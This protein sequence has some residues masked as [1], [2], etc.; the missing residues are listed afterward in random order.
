M[1]EDQK[2]AALG[3]AALLGAALIWGSGFV[4]MKDTLN[5]VS[6]FRLLGIRFSIGLALMSLLFFRRYR[7]LNRRCLAHGIIL[8][9]VEFAAYAVQTLGLTDTT[10]G[11]NAFLTAVYCVLVP[12]LDWLLY[13]QRPKSR[14]WLAGLLCLA[15]IG[16]I[17]LGEDFT[18]RRGDALSLLSGVLYAVQV[19]CLAH[20]ARE[21]DPVLLTLIT[22]A[23]TAVC[24]WAFS[25]PLEQGQYLNLREIWP[26]LLYLGIAATGI[27]LLLQ[28]LGQ[29]LTPAGSAGILLSLESVFG[30]AFSLL[31]GYEALTLRKGLGF[32]VV[33]LAVLVSEAAFRRRRPAS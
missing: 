16:L 28:N 7:L 17:A 14:N 27:A 1:N 32:C 19:T 5:S 25:L 22:F 3:S 26:Q 33:F 23:V 11:K 29:A 9:L 15:G 20:Y 8:G 12:F 30:A 18:V 2:K 10:P 6:V 4:V 21:D 24:S 13:R 31:F